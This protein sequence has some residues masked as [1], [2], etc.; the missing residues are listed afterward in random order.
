MFFKYYWLFILLNAFCKSSGPDLV[1]DSLNPYASSDLPCFNCV[2]TA[3]INSPTGGAFVCNPLPPRS[4]LSAGGITSITSIF[5]D[6]SKC[7]NERVNEC[8][9]AVDAEYT[10]IRA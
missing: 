7:R 10:G 5:L 1:K 4:V 2:K 9:N 8:N 3:S 6:F